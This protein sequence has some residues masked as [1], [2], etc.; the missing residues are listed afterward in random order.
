MQC[1]QCTV[2]VSQTKSGVV[3]QFQFR[4]CP[5]AEEIYC[6]IDLIPMF[7]IEE[8]A[9]MELTCLINGNMLGINPPQGWLHYMFK[10]PKDYKI[11][12]MLVESGTGKVKSVG[13]KAMNF[14]ARL[15][16]TK[17]STK[18][19]KSFPPLPAVKGQ[20]ACWFLIARPRRPT[21]AIW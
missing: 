15:S 18:D 11:I 12:Q 10:Y 7:P 13:L 4:E 8:I 1:E 2:M 19:W 21:H 20:E 9:T 14:S 16:S 5:T 3:L 17:T 6:S